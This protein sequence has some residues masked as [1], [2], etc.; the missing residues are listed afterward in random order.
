MDKVTIASG[1]C[2]CPVHGFVKGAEYG[3][4][5]PAPCGCSW[6]W[7][8]RTGLLVAT[9][10]RG[11]RCDCGEPLPPAPGSQANPSGRGVV[12]CP[13]CGQWWRYDYWALNRWPGDTG[14]GGLEARR[15]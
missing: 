11:P 4:Q 13:K 8:D 5:E 10:Y 12:Q 15:I 3:Q 14:T 6:V 9:E 1:G 7:D 2:V